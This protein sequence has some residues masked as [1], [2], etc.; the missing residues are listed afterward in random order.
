MRG[1]EKRTAVSV[2]LATHRHGE[3]QLLG[4]E[5]QLFS[6]PSRL[7]SSCVQK[8]C[9]LR[10]A[11]ENKEDSKQSW[12][13]R[14]L[15]R[16][17]GLETLHLAPKELWLQLEMRICQARGKKPQPL[18]F[19]CS[20]VEQGQLLSEHL[21]RSSRETLTSGQQMPCFGVPVS[22]LRVTSCLLA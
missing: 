17:F 22:A 14:Q 7:G 3:Q 12:R 2:P 11:G 21:G 13:A 18:K 4:G 5:S 20:A 6:F 10:K 15:R 19:L 8:A 9:R 1:T 16:C